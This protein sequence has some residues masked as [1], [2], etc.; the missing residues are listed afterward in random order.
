[1]TRSKSSIQEWYILTI[2][3]CHEPGPWIKSDWIKE[4]TRT[5]SGVSTAAMWKSFE[6]FGCSLSSTD[7]THSYF[8]HLAFI[9]TEG[10]T[11]AGPEI[12]EIFED[13]NRAKHDTQSRDPTVDGRFGRTNDS[14]DKSLG[15]GSEVGCEGEHQKFVQRFS[16]WH[17]RLLVQKWFTERKSQDTRARLSRKARDKRMPRPIGTRQTAAVGHNYHPRTVGP[18]QK[19]GGRA[20]KWR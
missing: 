19:A 12:I 11:I 5:I 1:M 16:K 6:I 3:V 13:R 14:T 10:P 7:I 8:P 15:R 4:I 18:S 20:A 17:N 9:I 2:I